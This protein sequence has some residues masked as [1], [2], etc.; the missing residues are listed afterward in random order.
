MLISF[1]CSY[2]SH[3]NALAERSASAWYL[4]SIQRRT[5]ALLLRCAVFSGDWVALLL[6]PGTGICK[7]AL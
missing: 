4:S 3:M 7:P 5:A 2:Q 6:N 1:R